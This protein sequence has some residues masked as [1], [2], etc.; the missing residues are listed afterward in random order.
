MPARIC[1]S[2]FYRPPSSGPEILDNVCDYFDSI[3]TAKFTNF[4]ILGDFNIDVSTHS[5]PLSAKLNVIMSTYNLS[6]MVTEYT[7]THHNGTRSMID[8]VF[9]SDPQP[10]EVLYNNTSTPKLRPLWTKNQFIFKVYIGSY[11]ETCGVEVQACRL[12]QGLWPYRLN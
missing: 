12:G 6:Q 7:H 11:K 9:V 10:C 2:I 8:L 1:L 5:H 3:D 4:I